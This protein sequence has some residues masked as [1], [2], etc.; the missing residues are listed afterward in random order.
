MGAHRAG[1]PVDGIGAAGCELGVEAGW[2][3]ILAGYGEGWAG[4]EV[5][6]GF[7]K[8][9]AGIGVTPGCRRWGDEFEGVHRQTWGESGD[10]GGADSFCEWQARAEHDPERGL[11][12]GVPQCVDEGAFPCGGA[13]S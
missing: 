2:R 1:D 12:G 11:A 6:G 7:R 10:S 13:F 9:V 4:G 5:D 8:R 3:G